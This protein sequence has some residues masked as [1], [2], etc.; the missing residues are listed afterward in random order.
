MRARFI[1]LM[2]LML[3]NFIGADLL[4]ANQQTTE[5]EP[6]AELLEFLAMFDQQDA[7]YVDEIIDEQQGNKARQNNNGE[8]HD[9]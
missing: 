3:A 1:V 4:W 9:N 2:M 5:T 7:D 6:D 8:Q